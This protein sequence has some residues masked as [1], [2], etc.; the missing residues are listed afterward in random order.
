[1]LGMYPCHHSICTSALDDPVRTREAIPWDE[2]SQYMHVQKKQTSGKD[3]V[4]DSSI[5]QYPHLHVYVDGLVTTAGKKAINI[6]DAKSPEKA[7]NIQDQDAKSPD[8]TVPVRRF[9]NEISQQKSISMWFLAFIAIESSWPLFSY[10]DPFVLLKEEVSRNVGGSVSERSTI[11]GL[12]IEEVSRNVGGGVSERSTIDGL[13]IG[14]SYSDPSMLL[15]EEVSRNGGGGV[16]ERSTIDGLGI[17]VF[18]Y[19]DP[20]VLLKEEVSRNGGGGVSERSII[21]GLGIG[22]TT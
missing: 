16:S 1:M 6:Q 22:V 19:S 15:K 21:D 4:L 17:G 3:S 7:S 20:F 8:I 18:S 12:G 2:C 13:G 14:F 10:S 9:L 11:D 5:D